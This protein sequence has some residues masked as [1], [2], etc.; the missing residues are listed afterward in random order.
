[1]SPGIFTVMDRLHRRFKMALT[2]ACL[3]LAVGFIS[4]NGRAQAPTACSYSTATAELLNAT[5][6]PRYFDWIR[7]LSGATPVQIDGITSTIQT[8]YSPLLFDGTSNAR[9]YDFVLEQVQDWHY[10]AAQVEEHSYPDPSP[11]WKNLI[12]TIPGQLHPEQVVVLSAHLDDYSNDPNDFAPGAEDNASGVAALMEAARLFRFYQF[13]KTIK[14]IWFTGEEQGMLGSIAYAN[15][16]NLTGYLWDVNLDMFGYDSDGDRCIELHVGT[17][18]A[19][20]ALG[21]CFIA[22]ISSYGLDLSYDYI[23]SGAIG[24][25]DHSSFWYKGIGAIEVL[26]NHFSYSPP[27]GGCGGRLDASPY[28]H[29][30]TDTITNSMNSTVGF[31]IARTGLAAVADLA[32]PLGR[33]FNGAPMLSAIFKSGTVELNWSPMLA[34]EAYRVFRSSPGTVGPWSQVALVLAN[35]WVDSTVLPGWRYTYHIEA[36]AP[37]GLCISGPS[38][39]IIISTPGFVLFLPQ[40]QR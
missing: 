32:G 4:A 26:E 37:D 1:V 13:E 21:Q 18:S 30:T 19:S 23:T 36:V 24:N 38:N 7:Q 33:C 2:I 22:S 20:D 8:R 5:T 3:L 29:T 6:S 31:D 27:G 15:T 35:S 9:A 17:L 28:Y 34:A 11:F 12:V 10:P 14:I 16:H 25:S 40:V 39:D